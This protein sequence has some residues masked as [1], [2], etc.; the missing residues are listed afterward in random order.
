MNK[1]LVIDFDRYDTNNSKRF[2]VEADSSW[3]AL[4]GVVKGIIIGTGDSDPEY[5]EEELKYLKGLW[6]EVSD[7][8][9]CV[10]LEESDYLVYK[11]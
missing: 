7:T 5:A 8:F 6:E 9:S 4:S 11:I 2:Y 3:E 1:Y 10:S